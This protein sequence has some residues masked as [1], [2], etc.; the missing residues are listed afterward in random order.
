MSYSWTGHQCCGDSTRIFSD[1]TRNYGEFYTDDIA[2]CFNAS[3]VYSD[4]SVSY[5][6]GVD[7]RSIKSFDDYFYKDLLYE[8]EKF[9]GCQVSTGK[10]TALNL[11]ISFTGDKTVGPY[12]QGQSLFNYTNNV[13][14]QCNVTGSYYCKDNAWRQLITAPGYTGDWKS[15]GLKLKSAPPGGEMIKNGDFLGDAICNDPNCKKNT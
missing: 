14:D 15:E 13:K 4:M 1:G 10:Y 12:T 2:G 7:E 9:L 3:R 5:S 11:P 8:N 6:K